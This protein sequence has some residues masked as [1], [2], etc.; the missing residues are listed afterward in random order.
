MAVGLVVLAGTSDVGVGVVGVG[1]C[2]AA[3]DGALVALAAS[4]GV[5]LCV[6]FGEEAS[7]GAVA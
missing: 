5:A 1:G 3:V 4:T 2:V 6:L 7:V